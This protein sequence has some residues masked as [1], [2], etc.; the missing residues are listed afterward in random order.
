VANVSTDEIKKLRELSG[1]GV[2]ECRN[3]L[4]EAN[5]DMD[6]AMALLKERSMVVAQKRKDKTTTQGL[7]EA[8]VHAGGRIG[9]LIELNCETDFVA[10]TDEFKQLAHDIAMQVAAMSPECIAKEQMKGTDANPEEACLLLQPFIKDQT[11]TIQRLIDQL[12]AKTGENIKI[13]RI[14]RFEIG[15]A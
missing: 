4:V 10:R 7:V 2:M 6:K 5:G 14:A 8:Y 15:E 13:N 3:I 1:A 12:I 9:A 11:V